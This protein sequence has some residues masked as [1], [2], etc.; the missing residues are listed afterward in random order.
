MSSFRDVSGRVCCAH[1]AEETYQRSVAT[2]RKPA[3]LSQ[4]AGRD[5]C[6]KLGQLGSH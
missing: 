6:S 3:I 5:L 4:K 1:L 2:S